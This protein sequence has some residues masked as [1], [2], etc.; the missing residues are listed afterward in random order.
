MAVEAAGPPMAPDGAARELRLLT[1]GTAGGPSLLQ[2]TVMVQS[3]QL[4]RLMAGQSTTEHPDQVLKRNV[5]LVSVAI[6]TYF[7]FSAMMQ[8][9][10]N[11]AATELLRQRLQSFDEIN[12][13]PHV[14]NFINALPSIVL[15][16][17]FHSIVFAIFTGMLFMLCGCLATR[18]NNTFCAGCFCCCTGCHLGMGCLAL[19]FMLVFMF[20][21]SAA[22]SGLQLWLQNCDPI[23][24]CGR[25]GTASDREHMVDCLATGVWRDYQPRFGARMPRNCPPFFL[26]CDSQATALV[27]AE[28]TPAPTPP[29]LPRGNYDSG[30]PRQWGRRLRYSRQDGPEGDEDWWYR[31]DHDDPDGD[32]HH[33]R[34]PRDHDGHGIPMPSD[35]MSECNVTAGVN[36][37]HAVRKE[38]PDAL[39]A[40]Q[41]FSAVRTVMLVPLLA[42]FGCG[43]W[44]GQALWSR[45]QS[46]QIR[47]HL[48]GTEMQ[49]VQQPLILQSLQEAHPQP[50]AG[51]PVGTV[52]QAQHFALRPPV[53]APPVAT[54]EAE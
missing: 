14:A 49:N 5:M 51:A 6:A 12:K 27:G 39:T 46:G 30:G 31:H 19:F 20:C 41:I 43:A 48:S 11:L 7:A 44:F 35:P 15:A 52:V 53:A 26:E 29:P 45:L 33:R 1:T 54:H 32:G 2:G 47:H 36:I 17:S 25:N 28:A 24:A 4:R 9:F 8:S 22:D 13:D 50:A 42:L 37:F 21:L 38:A 16:N 34:N 18:S 10:G 3:G 40:V 23:A